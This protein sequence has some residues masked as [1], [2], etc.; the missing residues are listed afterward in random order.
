[1]VKAGIGRL[2]EFVRSSLLLLLSWHERTRS[3]GHSAE[4]DACVVFAS[5]FVFSRLSAVNL[6]T[7]KA[8]YRTSPWRVNESY[9]EERRRVSYF[10][11]A[12]PCRRLSDS[13]VFS[14]NTSGLRSLYRVF[15]FSRS[16][17]PNDR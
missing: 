8:R 7:T 12:V 10:Q 1:M 3:G 17:S 6:H 9:G 4:K 2:E 11:H 14:A 13:T 15:P 5:P 16:C